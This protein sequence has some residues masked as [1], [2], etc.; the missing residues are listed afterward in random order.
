MDLYLATSACIRVLD[1]LGHSGQ[2]LKLHSGQKIDDP[3]KNPRK[4]PRDQ[5]KKPATRERNPRLATIRLSH[6]KQPIYSFIIFVYNCCGGVL[7]YSRN[8]YIG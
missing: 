3:Q 7:L 5:R 2:V 1:H 6:G 8:L 4:K